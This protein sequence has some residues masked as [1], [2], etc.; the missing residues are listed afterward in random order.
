MNRNSTIS[1]HVA[2]PEDVAG[3]LA[4]RHETWLAT[5]PYERAGITR[6]EIEEKIT[7]SDIGAHEE[8][9]KRFLENANSRT[10][11][12]KG[13][14]KVVGF[15][16]ALKADRRNQITSLYVFPEYHKKGIGT[17]LMQSALEW[18]GDENEIYIQVV[19]Y[20]TNAIRFYKK[21][22]FSEGKMTLDDSRRLPSG[23][24]LPEFEMVRT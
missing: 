14:D 3:I 21:F 7:Q 15:I 18:L 13:D 24:V 2:T 5:Y 11:V 6:E 23:K 10:W 17:M 12:A 16:G 4:V 20:N 22:R 1:I 8:W 9:S 19:T